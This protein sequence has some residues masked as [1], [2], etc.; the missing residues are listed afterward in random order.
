MIEDPS[1]LLTKASSSQPTN[2]Q[3]DEGDPWVE[4]P[5]DHFEFGIKILMEGAN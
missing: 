4:H 2:F 5:E 1:L 3:E